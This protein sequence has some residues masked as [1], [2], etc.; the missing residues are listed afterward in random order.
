MLRPPIP[1]IKVQSAIR[2][3]GYLRPIP[4]G[5]LGFVHKDDRLGR[6]VG[7]ARAAFDTD[8]GIN[9]TLSFTF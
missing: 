5:S 6:T 8:V 2:L 3:G 7:L 9:M 4:G 1:V